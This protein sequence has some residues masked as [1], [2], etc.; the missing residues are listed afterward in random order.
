MN[1]KAAS[2]R[3]LRKH[4]KTIID[5]KPNSLRAA[6]AKEALESD[7]AVAFFK[8]LAQYGCMFGAVSS[9]TYFYQTNAFFERYYDEIEELRIDVESLNGLPLQIKGTLKN[10]MV[11]K[12]FSELYRQQ[13]SSLSPQITFS[14]FNHHVNRV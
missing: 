2:E 11:R 5:Q 13:Y 14:Y 4:L 7:N 1:A 6:V 12:R 9:L 8:D 3:S 10:W